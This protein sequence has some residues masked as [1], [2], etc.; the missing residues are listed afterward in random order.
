MIKL[1]LNNFL[2]NV[3]NFKRDNLR[4]FIDRYSTYRSEK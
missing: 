4:N 2:N 3:L 1:L